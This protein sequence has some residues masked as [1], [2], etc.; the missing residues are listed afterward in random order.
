MASR[1]IK[2]LKGSFFKL[3]NLTLLVV[4][5][6]LRDAN[7]EKKADFFRGGVLHTLYDS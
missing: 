6:S 2:I 1:D 5:L 7:K 3:K 4:R